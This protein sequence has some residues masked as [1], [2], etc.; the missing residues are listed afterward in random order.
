[1]S[2]VRSLLSTQEARL[3][4]HGPH[5]LACDSEVLL[6]LIST[7]EHQTLS[8]AGDVTLSFLRDPLEFLAEKQRSHKDGVARITLA[9][10]PVLLVW[11]P[12][13]ARAV[14]EGD[15]SFQ[16]VDSQDH[17]HVAAGVLSAQATTFETPTCVKFAGRDSLPPKQLPRRQRAPRQR[18]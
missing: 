8:P 12:A 10:K 6:A 14:F 2:A 18:R 7:A 17:P 15:D 1:M 13:L 5:S 9:G 16:K 3:R 11:D 4:S